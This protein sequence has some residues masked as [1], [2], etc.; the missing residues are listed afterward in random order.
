MNA[1]KV[2]SYTGTYEAKFYSDFSFMENLAGMENAFFVVDEQVYQLYEQKLGDFLQGKPYFLMKAIEENKNIHEALRIA[3]KMLELPSKRNTVLI[4][5]GG[6]IVQ[7]VSAF[8]ANIL[9]RGIQWALVPTTLLAQADS[10]IG[11]KSSLN[12]EHYKNILGYFY[13][14]KEIFINT[15]FIQTL[16]EKDYLSGLGEIIKCA[17]MAGYESFLSTSSNL[18]SLLAKNE[19]ILLQEIEKAL[20]FKKNMIELDEFDRGPRNVMNYGHTFGHALESTSDYAIPHGQAVSYGMMIA[21]EISCKRQYITAEMKREIQHTLCQI[22]THGLLQSQY[23][24]EGNYLQAMKHD[25]KYT[26]GLHTCILFHGN[27]VERHADIGDEEIMDAV[28]IV[29]GDI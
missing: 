15:N 6:G 2:K 8:I 3:Q 25:K 9:Y 27:G 7:D 29:A 4:A 18:L 12:Y 24:S 14:P 17:L 23:F 5:I 1:L 22:V 16:T 21:N 26:G 10:C 13:P 11:S 20:Q 28:K 19:P